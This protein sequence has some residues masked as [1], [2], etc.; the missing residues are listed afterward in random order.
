M[1]Q[2]TAP[3]YPRVAD[4]PSLPRGKRRVLGWAVGLL[5]SALA[6]LFGLLTLWLIGYETG[7]VPFLAGLVIAVLPVPVYLTLVLWLDRYEAE[8]AWLLAT[9]FF[10][11]ALVAVFF[12]IILN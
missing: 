9:S 1:D 2:F 8:P 7:L 10:W 11:G 3:P 12:A 4:A 5:A 6:A